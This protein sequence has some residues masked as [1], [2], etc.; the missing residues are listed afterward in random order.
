MARIKKLTYMGGGFIP[1]VPARNLS[2][3]E[4]KKYGRGRL[5]K[6]GLYIEPITY[7]DDVEVL[8]EELERINEVFEKD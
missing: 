6:S 2:V 4:V 8:S 5:I 1:G 7:K 3:D